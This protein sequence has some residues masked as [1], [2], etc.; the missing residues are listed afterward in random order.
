M[1]LNI[2]I[3]RAGFCARR[4]A[5]ALIK[6]GKVSV[7]G[8]V[9]REPWH[10]VGDRQT[11]TVNGRRVAL[12][13]NVYLIVNKPKGVTVTLED[14]FAEKKITDNIP[15]RYGRVYPVGR[16]DKDS[17]GLILLTNDGDL[18]YRLTHPKFEVEKEY[19]VLVR[20]EI[21]EA[22]AGRL[23]RGIESD[24]ELLKVISLTVLGTKAGKTRVRVIASEGKKRH[25]RRL[26][27][28]V[29][30][31]VLD[32]KRV[33]IGA[34]ALSGL[35]EGSFREMAKDAI[36]RLTLGVRTKETTRSRPIRKK[37]GSHHERKK[38]RRRI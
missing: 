31:T 17:R 2:Y 20:G 30:I 9:V 32:L 23:K 5:D 37:G 22:T 19:I 12:E 36:Y 6:E 27:D 8:E 38:G 16:L 18:C 35:E 4:K 33:R 15:K 13:K 29:G 26:F 3:A 28:E 7:A 24:G 1:H 25:I 11:V 21:D 10:E 14:K 34:L